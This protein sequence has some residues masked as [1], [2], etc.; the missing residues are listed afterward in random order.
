MTSEIIAGIDEAGRG[1]VIGPLV[2]AGVS[3]ERGKEEQLRALGV[4]DSK[5]LS[6]KRR[7]EL[8][9]KIQAIA[10]DV[11]ILSISACRIDNLRKD[12]VNLNRIEELKMAEKQEGWGWPLNSRKAHYFRDGLAL[13]GKWMFFGPPDGNQKEYSSDDCKAC[14]R[15]RE[16]EKAG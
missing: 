14:S 2:V 11:V 8:A 4:K 1:S 7:E 12:G 10:K 13:C 6:P 9:V 3:I 16:K 15:K 5:E